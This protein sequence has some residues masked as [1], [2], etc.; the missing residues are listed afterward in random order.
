M[1]NF[2]GMFLLMIA[3]VGLTGIA[4][5]LDRVQTG[6]EWLMVLYWSGCLLISGYAGVSLLADSD[7]DTI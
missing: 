4:G 6:L 1:K 2:A 7:R 3:I 5:S